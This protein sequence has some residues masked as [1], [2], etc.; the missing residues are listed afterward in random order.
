VAAPAWFETRRFGCALSPGHDEMYSTVIARFR[1][2]IQRKTVGGRFWMPRH[3]SGG[4]RKN[5]A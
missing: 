5:I 1:R 4:R 2:A 3:D